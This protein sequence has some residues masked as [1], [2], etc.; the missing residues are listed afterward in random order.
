MIKRIAALAI[1]LALFA[2]LLCGCGEKGNKRFKC[3]YTDAIFDIYVDT[4][5]GVEWMR[6]GNRVQPVIDSYGNPYVYPA[7]DAR[8]DR[9][10]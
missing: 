7:F 5:T 1:A 9:I 2:L 10:P 8:E 3:V 6:S 4:E